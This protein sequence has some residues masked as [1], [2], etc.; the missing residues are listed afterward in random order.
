MEGIYDNSAG[1][2]PRAIVPPL[3]GSTVELIRRPEGTG[4]GKPQDRVDVLVLN[5]VE[6][7]PVADMV[8]WSCS[9][10][11]SGVVDRTAQS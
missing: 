2:G 3:V 8:S 4:S 11:M 7:S 10:Q 1:A 9:M 5:Y 6:T